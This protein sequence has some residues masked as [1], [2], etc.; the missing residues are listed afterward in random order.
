MKKEAGYVKHLSMGN[1]DYI[2]DNLK[3][4]WYSVQNLKQ[5]LNSDYL[6]NTKERILLFYITSI[7]HRSC[8]Y[9]TFTI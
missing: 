8:T 9:T 5:T 1:V 6:M 4:K 7:I 2:K 3:L